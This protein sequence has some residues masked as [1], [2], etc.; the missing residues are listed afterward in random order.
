MA[1]LFIDCEHAID[2]SINTMTRVVIIWS[3]FVSASMLN[4]LAFV[5]FDAEAGLVHSAL[6]QAIVGAG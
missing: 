2:E 3:F 4:G 1:T 6:L 5:T